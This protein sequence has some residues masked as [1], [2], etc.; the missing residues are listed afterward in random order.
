M[1][2][3]PPFRC[4]DILIGNETLQFHFRD[5]L[6]CIR[7]IYGDPEFAQD[8]VFAPERHYVD[9]ERTQRVYDEMY[10]GDWWWSVQVRNPIFFVSLFVLRNGARDRLNHD[11]LAQPLYRSFFLLTKPS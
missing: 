7:A 11:N 2:G 3:R 10:T 5:V 4:Q 1:P 9:H 6:H 8:L